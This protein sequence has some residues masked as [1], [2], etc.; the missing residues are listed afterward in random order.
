MQELYGY[1]HNKYYRPGKQPV[2]RIS[3]MLYDSI[4]KLLIEIHVN[5]LC[6]PNVIIVSQNTHLHNANS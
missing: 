6:N 5:L 3:T 1:S 2:K 4:R